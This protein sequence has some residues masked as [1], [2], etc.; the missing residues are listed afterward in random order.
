MEAADNDAGDL[1]IYMQFYTT[2][3][4]CSK[5][6]SLILYIGRVYQ[7]LFVKVVQYESLFDKHSPVFL[8]CW[9]TL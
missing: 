1:Q 5:S 8:L 3:F 9:A 7:V 6:C 4:T 2:K